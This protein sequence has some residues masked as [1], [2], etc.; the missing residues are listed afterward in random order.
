MALSSRAVVA[1]TLTLLYGLARTNDCENK[2]F[3][4]HT[5][6]SDCKHLQEFVEDAGAIGATLTQLASFDEVV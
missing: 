4:T 3:S 2:G 6:C 5:L 1:A